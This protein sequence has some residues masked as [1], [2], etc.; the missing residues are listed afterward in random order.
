M[1][2]EKLVGKDKAADS[3][4]RR[5]YQITLAEHEEVFEY[6]GRVC[7]MCKQPVPTGKTRLAVDHRHNDGLLRGLLC[8]KCNR[9]IGAFQRFHPDAPALFKAAFEYLQS[10]PFTAVFGERF[11][12]PGKVGTKKRAKL[13]KQLA[14]GIKSKS[15]AG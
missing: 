11:C 3:R 14:Q 6:Q 15:G 2:S 8:W 5:E 12:V 9:A 4:L 7:A 13:L 10:P 1:T